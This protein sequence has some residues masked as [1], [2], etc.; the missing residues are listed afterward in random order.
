MWATS[1]GHLIGSG[2]ASSG[3]VVGV[4][5]A[6]AGG[7]IASGGTDGT[8]RLFDPDTLAPVGRPFAGPDTW[9]FPAFLDDRTLLAGFADGSVR[10]YDV[11]VDAWIDRACTIAG[12]ELTAAEATEVLPGRQPPNWCPITS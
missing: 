1:D 9:A 8:V 12:R 5:Y 2:P 4:A 6:P 3:F 11:A 10:S 7:L